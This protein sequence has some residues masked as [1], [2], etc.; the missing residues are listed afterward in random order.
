MSAPGPAATIARSLAGWPPILL[1]ML[2]YSSIA[3]ARALMGQSAADVHRAYLGF[4]RFC[5]KVGGTRLIVNGAEQ[6]DPGQAYVVVSTHESNWDSLALIAALPQLALRFVAKRQLMQIPLFGWALRISGNIL[7]DRDRSGTDLK[8]IESQMSKR[9]E[10]VSILFYAEG[11]RTRDG[12]FRAFKKGA[13]ATALSHGLPIL[14][15]AISGTRRIWPPESLLLSAGP[16]TIEV[17]APILVAGLD[18]NARSALRDQTHEVVGKLR[19]RA[20]ERLRDMDVDPG[21]ID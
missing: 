5:L 16:A 11:S 7:V 2:I 10:T 9:A 14:P 19:A 20:R 12:S 21:G 18:W 17:G 3:I 6:I 1:A 8:R 4:G 15:V 13:F